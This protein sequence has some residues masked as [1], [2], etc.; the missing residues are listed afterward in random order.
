MYRTATHIALSFLLLIATTGFSISKHRCEPGFTSVHFMKGVSHDHCEMPAEDCH[1][2]ITSIK[3]DRSF[4]ETT[5]Q[6]YSVD[7]VTDHLT[8]SVVSVQPDASDEEPV[9]TYSTFKLPE[10]QTVLARLQSYLL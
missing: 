9:F 3:I 8:S 10:I 7:Q 4:L 6:K 5:T 2:Q 1:T